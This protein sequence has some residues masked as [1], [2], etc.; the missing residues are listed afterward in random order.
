MANNATVKGVNFRV[1][2]L[3]IIHQSFVDKD[4]EKV[5]TFEGRVIAI[6]G[7]NPNK[8]FTVRRK[9]V[10]N[11]G[12]EKIYPLNSPMITKV[13]VK[14]SFPAKKAKLYYLRDQS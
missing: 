8:T 11:I 14:K 13:E 2:D 1:G 9:G 10:D 7:Q 12:V 4:K 6:K 3:I 5:Q